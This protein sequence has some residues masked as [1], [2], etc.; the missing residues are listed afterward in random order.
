MVA[1]L[2]P[3]PPPLLEL[4]VPPGAGKGGTGD[5]WLFKDSNTGSEVAI[6][7]IR[8]PLPKVLLTNIVR[9]FQVWHVLVGIWP[10][11]RAWNG[12]CGGRG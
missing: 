10:G 8:R 6:K 9:E 11:A 7:F 2:L 5:T 3:H 4:W 1:D 12:W